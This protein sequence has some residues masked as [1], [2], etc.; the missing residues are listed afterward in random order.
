M[1]HAYFRQE[2]HPGPGS[3]FVLNRFFIPGEMRRKGMN[4]SAKNVVETHL[5]VHLNLLGR[6]KTAG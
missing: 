1:L 2:R 3:V 4:T 6:G 5:L